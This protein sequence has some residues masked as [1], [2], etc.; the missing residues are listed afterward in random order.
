MHWSA[1]KR[2]T[3]EALRDEA[4]LRR[5]SCSLVLTFRR[6]RLLCIHVSQG[7]Y[8]VIH[9]LGLHRE[10][11]TVL[12]LPPYVVSI[13]CIG[14]QSSRGFVP[15]YFWVVGRVA[16][17]PLSS[18]WIDAHMHASTGEK[19]SRHC[20]HQKATRHTRKQSK[21]KQSSAGTTQL[22]RMVLLD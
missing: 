16:D 8:D 13:S 10:Y 19:A 7:M 5:N 18:H 11:T 21:A 15:N 14:G 22:L 6:L 4:F 17:T 9:I 1:D 12:P 3:G 20:H 2:C